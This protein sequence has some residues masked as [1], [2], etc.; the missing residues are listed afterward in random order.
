M[1]IV[2]VI[3]KASDPLSAP[4]PSATFHLIGFDLSEAIDLMGTKYAGFASSMIQE[5]C[6]YVTNCVF[7]NQSTNIVEVHKSVRWAFL[8][9]SL[10]VF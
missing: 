3:F 1:Q 4:V 5:Y 10:E 8:V 9:P 7:D 2:R 6:D